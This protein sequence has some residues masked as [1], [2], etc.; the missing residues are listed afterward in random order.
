MNRRV[1]HERSSTNIGEVNTS[2]ANLLK[3]AQ[4]HSYNGSFYSAVKH[5]CQHWVKEFVKM[6]S[7]TLEN[8][9]RKYPT[10]SEV[11]ELTTPG[12]ADW[13]TY[14][15]HFTMAYIPQCQLEFR[16]ARRFW[17]VNLQELGCIC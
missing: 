10:L 9:M 12:L 5:N 3:F 15:R 8:E 11:F 17:I 13:E 1:S 2:P 16:L 6:I 14:V 4:T 7:S